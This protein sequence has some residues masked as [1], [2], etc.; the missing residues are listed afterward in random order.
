MY[1]NNEEQT[2][3][4]AAPFRER[5]QANHSS[6]RSQCIWLWFAHRPPPISPLEA[7]CR[8]ALP[9]SHLLGWCCVDE[10]ITSSGHRRGPQRL[11]AAHIL[12][13]KRPPPSEAT[14]GSRPTSLF[15]FH[16][17][18][19]NNNVL[20]VEP[21][22]GGCGGLPQGLG[23]RVLNTALTTQ[24][25]R[26]ILRFLSTTNDDSHRRPPSEIVSKPTTPRGG[27]TAFGYGLPT[28]HL[29]ARSCRCALP[30]T[31]HPP[32]SV[33]VVGG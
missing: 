10:M 5:E 11:R 2:I 29:S 3:L 21:Q 8:C 18:D 25:Y 33:V 31:H 19:S 7:R 28:A 1:C 13:Y 15:Y 16:P 27:H 9:P 4:T 30:P 26:F 6:G 17:A 14:F 32:R 12:S 20:S 22:R 24:T 23:Q